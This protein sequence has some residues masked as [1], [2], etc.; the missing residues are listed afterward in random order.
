VKLAFEDG[1][2]AG[3]NQL[4]AFE[5]KFRINSIAGGLIDFVPAE[6]AVE[7]IFVI[8]IEAKINLFPV[9]GELLIFVEHHELSRAP[10]LPGA[11]D[12]TPKFVVRFVITA[13]NKIIAG[14]L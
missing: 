4:V 14:R 1:S 2:G 13:A 7:L 3:R 9:W 8:V 10:G 6:V 11:P 5:N 12:V